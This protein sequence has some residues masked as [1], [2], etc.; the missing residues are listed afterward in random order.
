M[1]AQIA[2]NLAYV[3]QAASPPTGNPI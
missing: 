3:S 2:L 1:L